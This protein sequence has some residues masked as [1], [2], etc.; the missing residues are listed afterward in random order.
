MVRGNFCAS[1]TGS[2]HYVGM[3]GG[4]KCV[5]RNSFG[6]LIPKPLPEETEEVQHTTAPAEVLKK[7]IKAKPQLEKVMKDLGRINVGRHKKPISFNPKDKDKDD[8]S[9]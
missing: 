3:Y 7:I 8:Y 6:P 1:K 9:Y 5:R 4:G 2:G